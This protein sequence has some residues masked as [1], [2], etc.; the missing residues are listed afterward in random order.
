MAGKVPRTLGMAW[1]DIYLVQAALKKFLAR[2]ALGRGRSDFLADLMLEKLAA[3]ERQLWFASKAATTKAEAAQK[4]KTAKAAA[5]RSIADADALEVLEQERTHQTWG[6]V[7]RASNRT[8]LSQK[9][10]TALRD[11]K[12]HL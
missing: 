6:H 9:T 7:K 2:V 1:A 10:L 11:K 12:T 8:K 3:L 4:A 5:R